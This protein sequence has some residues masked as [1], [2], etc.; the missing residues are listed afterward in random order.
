MWKIQMYKTSVSL[1]AFEL[2]RNLFLIRITDF[3]F[4]L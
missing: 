3:F 1:S 4:L 2:S